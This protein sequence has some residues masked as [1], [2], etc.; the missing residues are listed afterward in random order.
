MIDRVWPPSLILEPQQA[1]NQEQPSSKFIAPKGIGCFCIHCWVPNALA[2]SLECMDGPRHLQAS[3]LVPILKLLTCSVSCHLHSSCSIPGLCSRLARH[4]N[5][6]NSKLPRSF[7]QTTTSSLPLCR[8]S[9][10]LSLVVLTHPHLYTSPSI[11]IFPNSPHPLRH[12]LHSTSCSQQRVSLPSSLLTIH[13]LAFLPPPF[14]ATRFSP[15]T[16][17]SFCQPVAT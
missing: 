15:T 5:I 2:R 17:W 1:T 12:P 7:T 13:S 9:S 16:P 6:D 11:T 8:T 4:R 10:Y 14:A 3:R